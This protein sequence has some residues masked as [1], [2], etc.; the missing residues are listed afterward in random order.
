M[1]LST[2]L[3]VRESPSQTRSP[4]SSPLQLYS[5]SPPTALGPSLAAGKDTHSNTEAC[6]WLSPHNSCFNHVRS[7]RVA[8]HSPGEQ[9]AED[10]QIIV[11]KGFNF[12]D[13]LIPKICRAQ[14]SITGAWQRVPPGK[15][16]GQEAD[17]PWFVLPSLTE[18]QGTCGHQ[19]S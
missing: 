6:T 14:I 13:D 12:P 8:R 16:K 10:A 3:C 9:R 19:N 7:M 2:C 11:S 18:G 17:F 4:L 5:G 15:E 1:Y